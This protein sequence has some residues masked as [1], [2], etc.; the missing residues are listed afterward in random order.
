MSH[1]C[2]SPASRSAG[3]PGDS[4]LPALRVCSES[5]RCSVF[6]AAVQA[7]QS[8]KRS[9]H[10]VRLKTISA[11]LRECCP[12]NSFPQL[13]SNSNRHDQHFPQTAVQ[14]F[15]LQKERPGGRM[16]QLQP[17]IL[18]PT[19]ALSPAHTGGSE[20]LRRFRHLLIGCSSDAVARQ[21][22]RCQPT[23]F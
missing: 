8:L 4:L 17:C 22:R 3:L 1:H 19:A 9:E 2:V 21:Q 10:R 13:H 15:P 12:S 16:G 14:C 11:V 7:E 6:P 20:A 18:S 23:E 5:R